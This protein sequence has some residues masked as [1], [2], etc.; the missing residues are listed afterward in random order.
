VRRGLLTMAYAPSFRLQP[1]LT[2]D[3][4][5]ARNGVAVL[6]EVFDHVKQTRLW[7]AT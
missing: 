1:A 4:A 7:E 2:I 5:T 3:E 6:R